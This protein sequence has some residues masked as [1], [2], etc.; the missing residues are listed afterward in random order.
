MGLHCRAAGCVNEITDFLKQL[1]EQPD[2][3]DAATLRSLTRIRSELERTPE[4]ASMGDPVQLRKQFQLIGTLQT[5]QGDLASCSAIQLLQQD[6]IANHDCGQTG[7]GRLLTTDE[8]YRPAADLR[9]RLK[10]EL[11]PRE[12]A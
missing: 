8:M 4:T 9:D 12:L 10:R 5:F 11:E 3:R 1:D 6:F 2:L 7:A